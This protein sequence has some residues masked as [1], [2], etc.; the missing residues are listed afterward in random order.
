MKMR[1]L[2]SKVEEVK[3][4]L[5]LQALHL[6]WS[7]KYKTA[8]RSFTQDD[9]G[10]SVTKPSCDASIILYVD[11]LIIANNMKWHSTEPTQGKEDYSVADSM[12]QLMKQHNILVRGHNIFWDDLD[13]NQAGF[14]LSNQN[15]RVK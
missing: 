3:Q 6:A 10:I 12:M 9:A 13:S 15:I 14:R 11:T 5:I 2:R 7:Q 1:G 4:L 8:S